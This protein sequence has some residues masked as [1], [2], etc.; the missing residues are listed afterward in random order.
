M[1]LDA[2]QKHLDDVS[3]ALMTDDFESYITMVANPLVVITEKATT[4]VTSVE[5]Y[6]FGFDSYAGML[7]TEKATDLIRLAKEVSILGP[8]L[9]T[10]RLETN[11]MSSGQ[12]IYGPFESAMSLKLHDGRWLLCSVVSPVHAEKWPINVQPAPVHNTL[13]GRQ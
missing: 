5:Q 7:R 8:S 10:G 12:R 11:I 6:R 4:I 3:A 2:F 13:N 9:M 1:T